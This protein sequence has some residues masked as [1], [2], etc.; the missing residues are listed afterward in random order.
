MKGYHTINP[1]TGLEEYV[2]PLYEIE[3]NTFDFEQQFK[4]E[5]PEDF[6][7]LSFIQWLK[8]NNFSIIKNE[9]KNK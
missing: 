3:Q 7:A 4:E 6:T 2:I 1:N 5:Q 8:L 9:R